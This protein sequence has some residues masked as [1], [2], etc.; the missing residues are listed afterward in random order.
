MKTV[1][2]YSDYFKRNESNIPSEDELLSML[3][4]NFTNYTKPNSTFPVEVKGKDG[5][6]LKVLDCHINDDGKLEIANKDEVSESS[7][8][9]KGLAA[10]CLIGGTLTSCTKDSKSFGYNI[11]TSPT[12][13]NTNASNTNKQVEVFTTNGIK[14]YNS[15]I[16]SS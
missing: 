11:G 2:S 10:L 7:K 16:Y 1:K 6:V 15:L 4:K 8:F 5:K 12:I 14:K 9:T 13:Y 3:R